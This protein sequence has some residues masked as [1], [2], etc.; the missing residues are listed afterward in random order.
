MHESHPI[1]IGRTLSWPRP[2]RLHPQ[3]RRAHLLIVGKTG[4]GKSTLLQQLVTADCHAGRGVVFIDPHGQAAEELLAA[5]PRH[6]SNEVVYFDPA[7]R[8]H[9]IGF[10]LLAG[11]PPARRDLVATSV[12][13]ACKAI[14]GDSWGPRLEYILDH[15]VA[16]LLALPR[17]TLLG[18]PRLLTDADF[19]AR[20]LR[21]V[22]DARLRAFWLDEFGAWNDRLRAEAIAPVLNKI[23]QFLT[24]VIRNIVGQPHSRL[25][26]RFVMDHRRI[27]IANLAKGRLGAE[28]SNL[29]GSL[30]VTGFQLAALA[31]IDQLEDERRDCFMVV[32]EFQNFATDSF[33][34]IL[35][36]AR[37]FRLSLTLAHQFL[38]QLS[39]ELRAAVFGNVGS[40]IAFKVGARDAEF[41]AR[42]MDDAISP[43]ALTELDRFRICA[44]LS[45]GG[46]AGEPMLARTLPIV[47]ERRG[48]FETIRAQSRRR[49]SR[50]RTTVERL[51]DRQLG[52]ARKPTTFGS[53]VR[54][55]A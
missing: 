32:D 19:R 36:E 22:G 31:R 50:P 38:D 14:W 53:S 30:L 17:A 20:A 35:S 51:V 3:D 28:R 24:P 4:V 29:L 6:R 45:R 52:G 9:P 41:L 48:S 10:N 11:V 1:T 5:I 49:F 54:K 23:G 37:K 47:P 55:H 2:L 27:F 16:T 7:D 25:D 39:P 34:D 44:L 40:I 8:E 26:L 42:E 15:S 21:H 12:V 46:I 43:S 18:I 33:G 13:S